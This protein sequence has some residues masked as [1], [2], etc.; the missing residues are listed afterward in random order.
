M[1]DLY[2]LLES[3]IESL[4]EGIARVQS[5]Y[6]DDSDERLHAK[7]AEIG[8]LI[9]QA[10]QYSYTLSRANAAM[11]AR[12]FSETEKSSM[13]RASYDRMKRILN[14]S[15]FRFKEIVLLL[16]ELNRNVIAYLDR[17]F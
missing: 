11:D 8:D 3:Q 7:S 13:S 10:L 4:E 16:R 9:A 2:K 14:D 17:N 6:K 1:S 15:Y 12:F 5:P